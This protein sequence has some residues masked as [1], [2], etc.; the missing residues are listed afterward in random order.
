MENQPSQPQDLSWSPDVGPGKGRG[1]SD[2]EVTAICVSTPA[3]LW[4]L[5]LGL[6]G[7]IFWQFVPKAEVQVLY[8]PWF[9][10]Q[11]E[12]DNI[13]SL[14][15]QGVEVRGV[16]RKEQPYQGPTSKTP[17]PVR[18]FYT[19]FPSEASIEPIVQ[20]LARTRDP[21]LPPVQI[22]AH[23]PNS[24]GLAWIVLLLPT[25]VILGLIYLMMRRARD[26]F[27]PSGRGQ[28]P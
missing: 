15:I 6:L 8:A 5:V 2:P 4:L 10:E 22:E 12:A 11:I 27:D 7:L 24:N 18:R 16:L 13:E 25:F 21:A 1:G 26:R 20:K 3:W 9:L 23:P 17:V 28:S 19:Y 14:S